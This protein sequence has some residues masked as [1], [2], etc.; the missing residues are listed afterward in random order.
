LRLIVKILPHQQYEWYSECCKHGY[1]YF[2]DDFCGYY[3]EFLFVFAYCTDKTVVLLI[4]F[5]LAVWG[6]AASDVLACYESVFLAFD[7]N[8]DY[9]AH[10]FLWNYVFQL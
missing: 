3:P 2:G 6:V 5:R 9:T 7:A 1:E 10:T 4:C 8:I